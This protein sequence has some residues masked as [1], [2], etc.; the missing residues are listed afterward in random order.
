MKI[1]IESIENG[2]LVIFTPNIIQGSRSTFYDDWNKAIDG[3]INL[4]E[5]ERYDENETQDTSDKRIQESGQ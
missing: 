2:C 5:E 1:V 3:A 4:L